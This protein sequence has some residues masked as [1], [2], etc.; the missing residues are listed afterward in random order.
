MYFIGIDISPRFS[1]HQECSSEGQ[2]CRRKIETCVCTMWPSASPE[3]RFSGHNGT[4]I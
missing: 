2:D 4:C 1:Y 3:H